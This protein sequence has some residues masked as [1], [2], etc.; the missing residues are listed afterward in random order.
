[1]E[2]ERYFSGEIAVVLT[3]GSRLTAKVTAHEIYEVGKEIYRISFEQGAE[4]RVV[5]AEEG[6][7]EALKRLRLDLEESGALL[8]C[9]GGSENVYPSGMQISMGPAI[10]AYR[11]RLGSPTLT[12]DVVNIFETD[13]TVIPSTVEQQEHF[14]QRWIRSL[15][16]KS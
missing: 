6:F 16:D 5:E 3:D 8:Y 9:F 11:T 4:V 7:F 14:H 2:S 15:S 13:E 10:L 12:R 1:M